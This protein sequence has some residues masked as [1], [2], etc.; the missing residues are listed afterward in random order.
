MSQTLFPLSTLRENVQKICFD[1]YTE[2]NI[3]YYPKIIILVMANE[4]QKHFQTPLKNL[5]IFYI[6]CDSSTS[7]KTNPTFIFRC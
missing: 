6:L 5:K 2:R 1:R 3:I 7:Q 4:K